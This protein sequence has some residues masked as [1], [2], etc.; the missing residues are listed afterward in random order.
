MI[1]SILNEKLSNKCFI[2]R[3]KNNHNSFTR[4][5]KFDF[6]SLF[7]FITSS[8]QSSIQR[9]LDHFFQSY[10]K[11]DHPLR[12]ISQ[13]AFSQARL[14]IKPEA[15]S[16]LNRECIRFFYDNYKYKKWKKFRLIGID[17]TEVVVPKTN[18]TIAAFGEY[19]TNLMNKTI[20]LTRVSKA[21]DVLNDMTLD[22]Q[23]V[24]RRTGEHSLAKKHLEYLGK[25]DLVLLDRG[26]PSY[27]LFRSILHAGC[28]FCARVPVSNWRAAKELVTS[29][30]TEQ[31]TEISPG[32]KIKKEYEKQKTDWSP[33]RVRFVRISLKS[34][35]E[36]VLV[37]SLLESQEIPYQEFELLYH[38]RWGIEELYKT[39]KHKL[40]LENFS[41]KSVV[42][43]QQD[44][45]AQV[46]LGNIT[47]ILSS[48]VN[49]QQTKK[50]KKN[51]Y[52][53]KVNRITALS[54]VKQAIPIL[55][56]RKNIDCYLEYLQEVMAKNI[57]PIRPG[58]HFERDKDK[59]RR[60]FRTYSP[61]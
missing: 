2:N 28:H 23:L 60:Y 10:F 34:G 11:L 48:Y 50:K 51:K 54:K 47:S 41:G 35:E 43:I 20:V 45:L 37:T 25:N 12:F 21:Y 13:S 4:N 39:D 52:Y 61:I 1:L 26:Y 49:Q 58:R 15:F 27:D 17:G 29:G 19:T 44:F 55:F 42:A 9:E 32:Y 22:A 30:A 56:T 7:L 59:R 6:K 14:K 3:F 5:R 8:I 53:Y 36:E 40:K 24:N 38:L 31:F 18:E 16:E 57:I 46:L 33:I